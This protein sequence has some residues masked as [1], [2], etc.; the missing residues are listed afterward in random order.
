MSVLRIGRRLSGPLPAAA[1]DLAVIL[2]FAAS[3]R[4]SHDEALSAAGI[5]AVAWPFAAGWAAGAAAVRLW[6]RP[7]DPRAAAAA[8]ALAMPVGFAL[9]ALSGRGL[10][11]GFLVVACAF[12]LATLVGWRLLA[13]RASRARA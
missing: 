11:P 8:W 2:A 10:A 3:G 7:A 13:A 9:R 12:L 1:A 6:R 5:V 4:S